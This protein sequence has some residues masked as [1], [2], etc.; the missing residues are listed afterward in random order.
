MLR[1]I[2]N[3]NQKLEFT[4]INLRKK[5]LPRKTCISTWGNHQ[6]TFEKSMKTIHSTISAY[7]A[8]LAEAEQ[9]I[10][11]LLAIEIDKSLKNSESKIWHGAP[12]WFLDGNPIVGYSKQKAGVKLM[13]WSGADFAEEK[14]NIRGGKFKDASIVFKTVSE[15]KTQELRRWLKK[16]KEIQWNYKDIVKNKGK[17][18]KL[19]VKRAVL[20]KK[21]EIKDGLTIKYHAN[22]KTV[23]SK[24]KI[25]NILKLLLRQ[26]IFL[27]WDVKLKVL[28]LQW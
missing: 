28:I 20:E 10:C 14:L 26:K 25:V 24:G 9:E 22:G 2:F 5:K 18:T 7:N 8:A 12:V 21:C 6:S 19:Q 11:E 4:A 17:L 15:I 16:A 27:F 3:P 23:W 13:F 1:Q